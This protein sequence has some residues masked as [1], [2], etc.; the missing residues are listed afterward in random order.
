M[1]RSGKTQ[2]GTAARLKGLRSQ[3]EKLYTTTK[4]EAGFQQEVSFKAHVKAES[5]LDMRRW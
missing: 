1:R 3:K 4:N 2:H 5:N